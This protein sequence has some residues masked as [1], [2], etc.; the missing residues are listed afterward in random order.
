LD[1]LIRQFVI[2]WTV[3][4]PIGTIPIF[5]A[6]TAPLA[7][8]ARARS[9]ALQAT[10]IS[11]VVLIFFVIA[12]EILLEAMAIPLAAFQVAGGIVLF[13]FALSMIFGSSKP[14]E[15]LLLV[16]KGAHDA[17]YPLAI[18]SIASPG[19]MMAAVLL[20]D[21]HRFSIVDQALTTLTMLLVLAITLV[22][23][24]LATR[25]QK[26]LGQSG[27]SV[28]SRI[29]GLIL[30]SVAVD[31]VLTGLLTYFERG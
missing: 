1:T 24:Y 10:A 20:T 25:I 23:M 27:A 13:L 22:L 28:I 19:A 3:I 12:G 16:E 26:V 18:P 15:E 14:E 5:L 6:V 30:A 2:F 7:S 17:V 29:M 11:A 4:D 9:V 31:H 21:N 8:A